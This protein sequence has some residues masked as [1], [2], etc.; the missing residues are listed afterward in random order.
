MFKGYR[1]YIL[2]FEWLK[3]IFFFKMCWIFNICL[4]NLFD[5]WIGIVEGVVFVVELIVVLFLGS[6]FVE[7]V[8]GVFYRLSDYVGWVGIM[9]VDG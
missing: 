8:L 4:E 9:W 5:D 6:V 7:V 3:I 2:I 1:K